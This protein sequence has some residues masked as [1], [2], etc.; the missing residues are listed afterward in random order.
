MTPMTRTEAV[1]YAQGWAD[2]WN[3]RDIDAVLTHFDEDVIFSSPAPAG[4]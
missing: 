3:A 4:S 2:E 1:A